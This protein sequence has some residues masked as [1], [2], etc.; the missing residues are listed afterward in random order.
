MSIEITAGDYRAV[1]SPLG[2]GLASLTYRALDLVTEHVADETPKGYD[3]QVLAPWP[4]RIEG[5]VYSF[6]GET[7]HLVVNDAETGS[8][9]HGLVADMW[10]N[11]SEQTSN[12]VTFITELGDTHGYPFVLALRATYLLSAEKGLL[13]TVGATNIGEG[14]APYGIGIHPYLTCGGKPIDECALT[15][16]AQSVLEMDERKLPSQI[17]PIE[18][19]GL[20]FR[21]E[22]VLGVRA[23]DNAFTG[24]PEGGWTVTL[25]HYESAFG[26]ELGSDE[27]W[28]QVFTDDGLGRRGLAVEPVTCPPNAFN[29]GWDLDV[30]EPGQSRTCKMTLRALV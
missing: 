13:L 7:H 27:K 30:L 20:D 11:V 17:L 29:S 23:I 10:W 12:S 18:G 2:A 6:E 3:G 8:A 22:D 5:A 14:S 1:L 28:V 25:R 16:P 9:L 4:G 24:L 21:S 19:S 15:I 26:V